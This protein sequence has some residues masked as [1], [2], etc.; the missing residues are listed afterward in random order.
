MKVSV[1]NRKLNIGDYGLLFISLFIASWYILP[2]IKV[3]VP[4]FVITCLG[5]YFLLSIC[6]KNEVPFNDCFLLFLG[7]I[8]IFLLY[9]LYTYQG[10]I[11]KASGI[12][13]QMIVS[14]IPAL[15]FHKVRKNDKIRKIFFYLLSVMIAFVFVKTFV[16][17]INNPSISR[18]LAHA[19]VDGKSTDSFRLKNIGGFGHAYGMVFVLIAF[20]LYYRKITVGRTKLLIFLLTVFGGWYIYLAEYFLALILVLFGLILC[21]LI[22][23]RNSGLKVILIF[24]CLVALFISPSIFSFLSSITEGTISSKFLE[25]AQSIGSGTVTGASST[26]RGNV[27]LQ[28]LEAFLSSPVWGI[29]GSSIMYSSIGG[30]STILDF[31]GQT[32]LIGFLAYILFLNFV[33]KTINNNTFIYKFVFVFY[34]VL[35]ILNPT[36]N[37]YEISA[38]IFLYVPLFIEEKM[39]QNEVK[40]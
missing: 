32:G 20:G 31:L 14:M 11:A 4:S 37:F 38:F 24:L 35:S 30:H 15:V 17:L 33:V 1:R 7:F 10:S 40:V 39:L 3:L 23:I 8:A 21:Y 26:A 16:E 36:M 29:S 28:S 2:S 34:I 9:Y 18:V 13:V 19:E 25:I 27:Y 6:L 5:I 22:E 12:V